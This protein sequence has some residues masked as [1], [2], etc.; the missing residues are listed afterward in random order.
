MS[1]PQ[2]HFLT[3]DPSRNILRDLGRLGS[4]HVP[5][6]MFSD[7][8]GNV[9]YPDWRQRLVKFELSSERLTFSEESLPFFPGTPGDSI[10]TGVT[11]YAVDRDAQVIY[12]V[13]YGAKV[14]AFH[15][16]RDGIGAV[17]DLGGLFDDPARPAWDYYCPNLSLGSNGRLY[18][19]IGGH[20]RYAGLEE[21]ILLME[22]DPATRRKR[23][24]LTFPIN[25]IGEV[26]GSD[27]R[28]RDGTLYFAGRREDRSAEARGESGS[29]RPFM[30]IFNP[31][32]AL[33]DQ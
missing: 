28:D 33:N 17:E 20:G 3:Y 2:V 11:A 22:F 9:Y 31:E 21:R 4:D 14:L 19:F 15:P 26:T 13:T 16:Q 7:W 6:V 8:W 32:R 1:Y 24:A 18:Y 27:V 23:I 5:R 10:V 25:Q 30:I 29:S 12:L